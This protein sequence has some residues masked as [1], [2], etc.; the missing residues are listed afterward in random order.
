MYVEHTTLDNTIELSLRD[1][2]GNIATQQT[3]NGTLKYN[4]ENETAITFENGIYQVPR[5]S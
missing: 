5:R 3:M 2:Y 1:R 4:G